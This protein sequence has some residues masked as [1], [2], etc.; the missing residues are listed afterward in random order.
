MVRDA[1]KLQILANNATAN[2]STGPQKRLRI[3]HK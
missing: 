3:G 1:E 2:Q